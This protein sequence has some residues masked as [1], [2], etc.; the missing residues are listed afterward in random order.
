MFNNKNN[1][2]LYHNFIASYS[3]FLMF[4]TLFFSFKN[5]KET[6]NLVIKLFQCETQPRDCFTIDWSSI[7]GDNIISSLAWHYLNF[8]LKKNCYLFSC[9]ILILSLT[10]KL[11]KR[12]DVMYGEFSLELKI[13]SYIFDIDINNNIVWA[14]M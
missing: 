3:K 7:S 8:S 4:Q 13:Y 11:Q 12:H 14:W 2:W 6:K 1:G 5:V 10:I 9:K